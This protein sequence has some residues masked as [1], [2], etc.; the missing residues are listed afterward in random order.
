[1]R[2]SLVLL[3]CSRLHVCTHLYSVWYVLSCVFCSFVS[4]I[5]C[6]QVDSNIW[7]RN[8]LLADEYRRASKEEEKQFHK[9]EKNA[10]ATLTTE[11][12]LPRRRWEKFARIYHATI[13][14]EQYRIFKKLTIE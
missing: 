4:F 14:S 11:H 6:S 8:G 9:A 13:L 5:S 1:M 3:F 10:L 12:S 2:I 7:F